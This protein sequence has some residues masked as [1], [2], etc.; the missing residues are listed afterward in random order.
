MD[1][2]LNIIQTITGMGASAILPIVITILGLVFRMKLG[3][4]IKSGLTVGV[5]FVGLTLVVNLLNDSLK[6]AVNYYAKL[7]SGFTISDIGWPAVGA[8]A[9]VVPF[10]ALMIPIGLL[11]NLALVRLKLVKTLNIDI[12]NY[13][14]FL[15]PGAFAYYLFHSFWLGL[16]V[17]VVLSV[18]A[19]FVGDWIAP[20]WQDQFGLEGTTSTT[21]I[22]T[23]W[24]LP[25]ALII[26]KIIDFIP[27]LNKLDISL[28]KLHKRIG[29]LGEPVVIGAIVGALLGFVS[30]RPI[31]KIVPMAM[32]IAGV[33]VLMPKVVGVMMEGLSPIGDAAKNFMTKRMGE[34]SGLN[35]GMDVALGLGD[36]ATITTTVISIPLIVILALFLPG[37]RLFP[38]GLLMSITYISVMT[39]MASKG[40]M[41]R[42]IIST[43]L[44][45]ILVIYL[46]GWVAPG[47]TAM[48]K[49]AGTGLSGQ[50]SDFTLTGP[51]ELLTYWFS[52]IF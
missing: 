42:S 24:T 15:V 27:G 34:D 26:N 41:L 23:A 47:A 43:V 4:A 49:G 3:E 8:A 51:W 50:G 31:T 48:L 12:W 2:L 30:H 19:L 52:L 21:L 11:V 36:P 35:I 28:D 22:H 9:W 29:I 17:A 13:M 39:V 1:T 32:G 20:K 16:G 5:G 37:I 18:L 14:H 40:N 6:P 45:S 44:F 46:E 38:V 7:G 33:M 10:A 25:V